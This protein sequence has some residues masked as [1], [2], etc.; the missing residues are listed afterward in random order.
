MTEARRQ[1]TDDRKQRADDRVLNAEGGMGNAE[2]K[3][4]TEDR[5]QRTEILLPRKDMG[6]HGYLNYKNYFDMR[7]FTFCVIP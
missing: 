6:T 5:G 7:I 2:R 1:R 3:K 4:M